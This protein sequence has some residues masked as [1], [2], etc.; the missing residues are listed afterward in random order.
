MRM[1]VTG[2]FR[3]RITRWDY[4]LVI[5]LSL[6]VFISLLGFNHTPDIFHPSVLRRD[7]VQERAALA[8]FVSGWVCVPQLLFFLFLV[9]ILTLV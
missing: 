2:Q 4:S 3:S 7:L 8:R 1:A 6:A 9:W 5:Y